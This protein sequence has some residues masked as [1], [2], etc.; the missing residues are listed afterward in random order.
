MTNVG[1]FFSLSGNKVQPLHRQNIFKLLDACSFHIISNINQLKNHGYNVECNLLV[2]YAD[3]IYPGIEKYIED[4]FDNEKL[5]INVSTIL[6]GDLKEELFTNINYYTNES[7]KTNFHKYINNF[8]ALWIQVYQFLGQSFNFSYDYY[9][10]SRL[11]FLT[12]QDNLYKSLIDKFYHAHKFTFIGGDKSK[13]CCITTDILLNG[14]GY[15]INISDQIYAMDR[16]A[17]EECFTNFH[18]MFDLDNFTQHKN[19]PSSPEEMLAHL[20]IKNHILTLAEPAANNLF[21]YWDPI[22]DKYSIDYL[23]DKKNLNNICQEI[24]MQKRENIDTLLAIE[25]QKRQLNV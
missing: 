23:K 24:D 15:G 4:I 1:I 12:I 2:N 20:L 14:L 13:G 19:N 11:D 22:C 5:R 3:E 21:L 7:I 6:Y 10:R 9:I 16:L 25:I 17:I 18:Y 8:D